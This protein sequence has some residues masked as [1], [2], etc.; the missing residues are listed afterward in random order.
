M[1]TH[2]HGQGVSVKHHVDEV[3]RVRSEIDAFKK[4]PGGGAE[5]FKTA[6]A[7]RHDVIGIATRTAVLNGASEA[8]R[9]LLL[10]HTERMLRDVDAVTRGRKYALVCS[11]VITDILI[12]AWRAGVMGTTW[13]LA[14][15]KARKLDAEIE[16]EPLV[17]QHRLDLETA[18]STAAEVQSQ[19]QKTLVDLRAAYGAAGFDVE[20][21]DQVMAGGIEAFQVRFPAR[22][23]VHEVLKI[24]W[25][26]SSLTEAIQAHSTASQLFASKLIAEFH[27]EWLACRLVEQSEQLLNAMDLIVSDGQV[28]MVDETMLEV[29]ACAY[30]VGNYYGAAKAGHEFG[31]SDAQRAQ[32]LSAIMSDMAWVMDTAGLDRSVAR[33][34]ATGCTPSCVAN[35]AVAP[36]GN[37]R[38]LVRKRPKWRR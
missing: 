17:V 33:A 15:T 20:A 2:D 4:S 32:N 27:D 22:C 14:E 34:F 38:H 13:A 8:C 9:N 18:R 3:S 12:A 10:M 36:A 6:A 29:V 24:N 21:A 1:S 31:S 25:D 35:D 5:R 7:I 19:W 28:V 23:L 26:Q 11:S 16:E 30:F 37:V